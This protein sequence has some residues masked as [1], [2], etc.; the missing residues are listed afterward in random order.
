MI[1]TIAITQDL[2][3]LKQDVLLITYLTLQLSGSG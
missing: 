3:W 2:R 1:R